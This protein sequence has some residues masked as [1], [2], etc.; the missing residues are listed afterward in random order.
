M[1]IY[2]QDTLGAAK[3]P[4]PIIAGAYIAVFN[5]SYPLLCLAASSPIFPNNSLASSFPLFAEDVNVEMYSLYLLGLVSFK[6]LILVSKGVVSFGGVYSSGFLLIL[7]RAVTTC[8]L[9]SNDI[10]F[11]TFN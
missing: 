2:I 11:Y 10:L 3:A 1:T 7:S 9:I 4:A 5:P 6:S 8:D